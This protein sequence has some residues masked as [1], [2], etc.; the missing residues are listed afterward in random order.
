[1]H[2]HGTYTTHNLKIIVIVKVE[3]FPYLGKISPTRF[4]KTCRNIRISNVSVI[5]PNLEN[6]EITSNRRKDKLII[7]STSLVMNLAPW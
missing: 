4:I 5:L 2:T 3:Y 1:M 7:L 6:L